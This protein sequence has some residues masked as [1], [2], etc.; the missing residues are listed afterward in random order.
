MNY[1]GHFYLT[2]LLFS[3]LEKSSDAR[4]INVSSDNHQFVPR[5]FLDDFNCEVKPFEY[6]K[7]F[8]ISKFMLVVF[9]YKLSQILNQ[10]AKTNVKAFSVNPGTVM[11]DFG[12]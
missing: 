3:L 9:A 8:F 11:S 6:N 10:H 4:I 2:H 12:K 1:Y 7:Q 5:Y